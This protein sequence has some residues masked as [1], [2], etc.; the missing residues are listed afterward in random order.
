[1]FNKKYFLLII[2]LGFSYIFPPHTF[3]QQLG[4][5]VTVSPAII[6]LTAVPGSV[7][8]QKFRI[9]NNLSQA[10]TITI[11]T[12]KMT[13]T[14]DGHVIPIPA[15]KGDFSTSWIRY[16][17]PT[18]K[19]LPREW[20][21]VEFS[22]SIPYYAVRLSQSL[23]PTDKNTNETVLGEVAI[24]ILLEVKREGAVKQAKLVEFKANKFINEY[25]PVE[26]TTVIANTGNVHIKPQ[27][28]IFVR[29]PGE[30]DLGIL[31]VNGDVGNILPGSNRSFL[32]EW[33]DG[34]LVEVPVKDDDSM[35]HDK[36]GK[37]ATHLTIKWDKLTSFRIG[38]YSAYMLLVYDNGTRD[39]TIEATTTFW[40]FPYKII[41]FTLFIIISS[42]FF[43]RWI[44]KLYIKKQVEKYQNHEI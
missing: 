23:D 22:L 33:T 13:G 14:T 7:V 3:A 41:L 11:H 21:E 1:M 30:K 24:P 43:V 15:Q 10:L 8:K 40:V 34:F 16:D 27:G 26:F 4:L 9:R 32:N 5:D 29:G 44:L 20:T 31:T 38:K 37:P 19:A 18:F 36:N 17:K 35:K 39:V 2:F 12:D 25:L 42:I 28:N 6:E